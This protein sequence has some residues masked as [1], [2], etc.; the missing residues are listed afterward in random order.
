MLADAQ[1]TRM[2]VSSERA[3]PALPGLALLDIDHLPEPTAMTAAEPTTDGQ[4]L[5]YV[6]YTSGSTGVPKGVEIRHQSIMRL[7]C[8]SDFM[9]LDEGLVMLHAA[10]LGFDASTLELWGPLLNGGC[11]AVH[12]EDV[13]TGPGL[14]HTIA[15]HGARAAWLTAALFNAVVDDDPQHLQGLA[16]LLIG[17]EALSV[18]HVSRF[19]HAVPG[20]ALINGYGPTECTT[21]AT[22]HRIDPAALIHARGVPIGRPIN[23]TTL[24]ILNRRGELLPQGV[25]G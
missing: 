8:G 22:T 16:E 19:M 9:T 24:R 15:H 20:T 1:V 7:V 14:A 6:M 21:F 5:A 3:G 13:P 25:R 23:Q 11:V 18:D 2:L 4:D 10:P 17:G 12:P